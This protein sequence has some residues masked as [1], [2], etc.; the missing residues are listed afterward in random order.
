MV[1]ELIAR[2]ADVAVAG[3]DGAA[4]RWLSI[5]EVGIGVPDVPSAVR[6]LTQTLALPTF[7]PQER[8]FAPIGDH[9][10]LLIL[11]D[12]ERIWFPT[13]TRR[14]ADGPLQ[15]RIDGPHDAHELLLRVNTTHNHLPTIR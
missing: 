3:A 10:G 2:E 13:L 15:V 6:E 11:V 9:D 8:H 14:P 7:P 1:L 12:H 4:P 5:S